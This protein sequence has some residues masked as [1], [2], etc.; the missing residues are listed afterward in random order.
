MEGGENFPFKKAKRVEIGP[1]L[2]YSKEE[3]VKL[4]IEVMHLQRQGVLVQS[5]HPWSLI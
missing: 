4:Q 2:D 5:T 1:N 3:A